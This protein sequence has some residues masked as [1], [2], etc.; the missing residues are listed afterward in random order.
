MLPLVIKII[1][2]ESNMNE[3]TKTLPTELRVAVKTIKLAILQSQY[4]AAKMVNREQLSLYFGIG[5]LYN[6]V[7]REHR[8]IEIKLS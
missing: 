3:Q 1:T 7:A 2:F 8:D 5:T 6:K 4:R